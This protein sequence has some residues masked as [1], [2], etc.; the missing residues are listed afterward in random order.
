MQYGERAY[1]PRTALFGAAGASPM[2]NHKILQDRQISN[3]KFQNHSDYFLSSS[4]QMRWCFV[5]LSRSEPTTNVTLAT[6][7]G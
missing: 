6:I 4:S 3:L 2:H 5:S 7:I 1:A